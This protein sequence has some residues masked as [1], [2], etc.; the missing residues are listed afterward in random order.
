MKSI[1]FTGYLGTFDVYRRTLNNY[2]G[3]E[4]CCFFCKG[5]SRDELELNAYRFQNNPE[6]RI[7]LSDESGGEGRNFQVADKVIHIDVPWSA[8]VIE[9]RIGRL[10]RIGRQDNNAVTS[11]VVYAENSL[12]EQLYK[13]WNE[14]VQLFSKSQPGLE[15]I[16]SELDSEI[17]KAVCSNFKYGLMDK[18]D[19]II[20]VMNSLKNR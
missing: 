12:E 19:E 7:M 18:I 4:H 9:Q 11:I 15:I 17:I 1:A 2:F 6:C 13:F 14:G 10:D 8:N 3:E 16:M 20:S 5:M